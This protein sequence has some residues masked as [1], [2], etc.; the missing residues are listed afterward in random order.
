LL[1]LSAAVDTINQTNV[2]DRL[3][4]WNG[5]SGITIN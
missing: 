3:S 1:D 5:V 2:V 4:L